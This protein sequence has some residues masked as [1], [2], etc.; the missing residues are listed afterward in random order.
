MSASAPAASTRA[1]S[2]DQ[3]ANVLMAEGDAFVASGALIAPAGAN[4]IARFVDASAVASDPRVRD[5]ARAKLSD[6]VIEVADGASG[7][8]T[9]QKFD[10]A[11]QQLRRL[12]AAVP[13]TARASISPRAANRWRVVELL[14]SADDL[15]QRYQIVEPQE[16]NAVA[17]LREVLRIDPKNPIADEMLTKAYGLLTEVQRRASAADEPGPRSS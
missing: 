16:D 15:M 7:M 13:G 14:L 8:I 1:P 2:P 5:M 4:A 3:R 11:R 17:T 12:S 9:R 10:G 6:A